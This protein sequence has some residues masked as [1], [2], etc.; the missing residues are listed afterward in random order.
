MSEQCAAAASQKFTCPGLT[1][2]PLA[3]TVAVSVTTLP[4]ATEL[5][6]TES[7]VTVGDF[8]WA[9]AVPEAIPAKSDATQMSRAACRGS[10]PNR[11]LAGIVFGNGPIGASGML[12]LTFRGKAGERLYHTLLACR[13][14][15]EQEGLD[16]LPAFQQFVA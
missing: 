15:G 14:L 9:E 4:A 5:A 6:L 12:S 2:A 3:V 1:L 16:C 10:K 7:E 13:N 8:A 11:T